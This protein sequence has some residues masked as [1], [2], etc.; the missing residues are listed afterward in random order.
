M[1]DYIDDGQVMNLRTEITNHAEKIVIIPCIMQ[2]YDG[3]FVE[4]CCLTRP[5]QQCFSTI[6]DCQ[7]HCERCDPKCHPPSQ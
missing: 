2:Y 7:A 1:G 5:N 3:D 4:Y 6:Q